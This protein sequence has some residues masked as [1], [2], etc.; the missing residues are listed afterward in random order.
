MD[1]TDHE[2]SVRADG[3]RGH[4]RDFD[5]EGENRFFEDPWDVILNMASRRQK[6]RMANDLVCMV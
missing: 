1:C 6:I 5:F 2:L 3:F 4:D